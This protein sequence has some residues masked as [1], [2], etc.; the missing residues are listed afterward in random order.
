MTSCKLFIPLLALTFV[1]CGDDEDIE[2]TLSSTEALPNNAGAAL[3]TYADIALATYTD[4]LSEA[5]SLD[6]ALRELVDSPSEQA[7]DGAREAWLDARVPYLQT[8][9]YRFYGGPIDNEVDG[10]EGLLN[11]W[12]MDE[13]YVD[14]VRGEPDSG[15]VNDPSVEIS[16]ESLA[17]LNEQQGDKNISTGYHAIEFLLWGQDFNE[18][19]PGERPYTDYVTGEGGTAANQ[20]R[21]GQY[22]LAVSELLMENLR[23]LVD[24]WSE[25][26]AG[27]YRE[28]FLA[29]DPG[30]ALGL[31]T[32]GASILSGF[33]T[34]GERLQAALDAREQ[35][36]E[37][38]CFSDNTHN[39]MIYDI[40][41][42]QN[43]WIGSYQG[44]TP[45]TTV[46]GTGLRDVFA[47]GDLEVASEVTQLVEQ[48]L[49]LARGMEVPFDQ[50]IA[51]GNSPGNQRVQAV[52]DSLL[53]LQAALEDDAIPLFG[54]AKL[55]PPE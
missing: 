44:L 30:M 11:A 25:G 29:M 2:E 32:S 35:E 36:E 21:R 7:L 54:L 34:G 18:E 22:L 3:R 33:E 12:P 46:T 26:D 9:V 5:E 47:A 41:G 6:E 45:A 38:S 48:S 42:V 20:E 13:N 31:V 43:V 52:V 50:E 49:A 27:N 4:S 55:N 8:E 1:A 23:Q 53:D 24:A 10:P 17:A 39:D 51:G 37:H 16:P 14:Y 19:G 40:V 28:R 15:I